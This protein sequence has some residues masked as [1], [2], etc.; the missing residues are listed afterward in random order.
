M[1]LIHMGCDGCHYLLF[2]Y[3]YFDRFVH[4]LRGTIYIF[5]AQHSGAPYPV[6]TSKNHNKRSEDMQQ[7]D[8]DFVQTTHNGNGPVTCNGTCSTTPS[9]NSSTN[10]S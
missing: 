7:T 3:C 8:H 10:A 5:V 2:T 1:F 4:H 9:G 6:R